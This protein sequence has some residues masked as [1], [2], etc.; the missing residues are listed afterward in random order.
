VTT[1]ILQSSRLNQALVFGWEFAIYFGLGVLCAGVLPLV[2]WAQRRFK[3]AKLAMR[4]AS[5]CLTTL[6]GGFFVLGV[7][8]A[9]YRISEAQESAGVMAK[10]ERQVERVEL[11][12]RL[13]RGAVCP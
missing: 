3:R 10:A 9:V 11:A 13:A 5:I 12:K 8:W 1:G 2:F 6:A 7:G 4:I